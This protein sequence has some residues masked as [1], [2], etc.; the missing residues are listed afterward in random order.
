VD[1]LRL[2][3]AGSLYLTRPTLFDYVAERADLER[4]AAELFGWIAAGALK[5]QIGA[6]LPLTEA[7]QAHRNLE[8]RATTGKVILEI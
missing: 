4:R 5:V 3:R 2:M 1:P 8:A 7:S 6:R